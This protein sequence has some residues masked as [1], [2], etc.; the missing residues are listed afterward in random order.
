MLRSCIAFAMFAIPAAAQVAPPLIQPPRPPQPPVVQPPRLQ[1]PAP[2]LQPPPPLEQFPQFG[3]VNAEQFGRSSVGLLAAQLLNELNAVKVEANRSGI[4]P[5]YKPNLI[6]LIDTAIAQCEQVRNLANRNAPAA[7]LQA[8]DQQLDAAMDRMQQQLARFGNYSRR[9]MDALARAQNV[10]AQLHAAIHQGGGQFP[11]GRLERIRRAAALLE[12]QSETLRDLCRAAALANPALRDL[13]RAARR[14]SFRAP[15]F[16]RAA[17]DAAAPA[18]LAENFREL[19]NH[20][21]GVL[22][23]QAAAGEPVNVRLQITRMDSTMRTLGELIPGGNWDWGGGGPGYLGRGAFAVGAGMGGGPRVRII[24]NRAGDSIYDFF[25]YDPAFTGGVRVA[26]ADL[27]GD[28]IPDLVTAPGPGM[29]ALIRVFNGRS[30]R[31]LTEFYAFDTQWTGGAFVAAANRTRDGRAWVAVSA[32]AGTGPHIKVFDLALGRELDS[33]LAFD[34]NFR[35]GCRIALGDVNADGLPDVIAAPGPGMEPRIRVFSGANRD[36]LADFLAFDQLNTRG[37]FVAAADF[38]RN[39]RADVI[40]GTGPG[41]T[42]MV[43]VF[44][45]AR[46]RMIGEIA[47]FP[48]SF[49]GGV[50]VSSFDLDGRGV[51][52]L[53]CAPGREPNHPALPI[54]IFSGVNSKPL[55][56]FFPFGPE[57]RGGAFIGSR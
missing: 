40:A 45:V 17:E 16:S 57:F 54:R 4:P 3:G 20:W 27:T 56:E 26:L 25:A 21:R 24:A 9:M 33:F 2:N 15:Y 32:E 37:L 12:E 41:T 39:G 22:T 11:G 50:R 47:P 5:I 36:L 53:A 6:T 38:T 18:Q 55:A 46:T 30:M 49:R 14:F 42:A 35:G 23:A 51:P 1:P 44:E 52:D 31:L 13:D 10:D 7:Q 34:Q 29:P 19:L 8:A 48:P 28:G 43:R